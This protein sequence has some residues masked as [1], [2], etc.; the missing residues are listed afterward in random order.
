MK[1]HL[2][3]FVRRWA[4]PRPLPG[5][6][7]H[8]YVFQLFALDT[9]PDP[10]LSRDQLVPFLRQHAMASGR[11]DGLFQRD[12]LARPVTPAPRPSIG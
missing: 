7:A 10:E 2:S 11:L 6:G 5:H 3:R 9:E 12:W 8:R 1:E 4:G